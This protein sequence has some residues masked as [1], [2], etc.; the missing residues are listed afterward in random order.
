MTGS[1]NVGSTRTHACTHTHTHT[2]QVEDATGPPPAAQ[3]P[4]SSS[5]AR[6][7]S[8]PSPDLG[9]PPEYEGHVVCMHAC[10]HACMRVCMYACMNVCMH[11]CMYV[12]RPPSPAE[13]IHLPPEHAELARRRPP[14]VS[15]PAAAISLAISV[16]A[17]W[18][19]TRGGCRLAQHLDRRLSVSPTF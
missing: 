17:V 14:H 12:Y 19:F 13:G 8:P 9:D 15:V 16:C 3:R 11:V 10:M 5:P 18:P 2:Q 4:G 7:R 6:E 1:H